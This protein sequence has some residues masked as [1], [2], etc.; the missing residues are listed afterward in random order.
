MRSSSNPFLLSY[1]L[2]FA[3][4]AVVTDTVVTGTV[5]SAQTVLTVDRALAIARENNP[6]FGIADRGL[7]GAQSSRRELIQQR[8]PRVSFHG[9]AVYAPTFPSFGYDPALTNGGQIGAQVMIEHLL[10]DGGRRDLRLDQS[11]IDIDLIGR[12]RLLM[13]RDLR[14]NVEL[15]F[16]DA[17]HARDEV[18]L[19]EVNVQQLADYLR[20]VETM[21]AGSLVGLTDVLKT[22]VRLSDARLAL[23]DAHNAADTARFALAEL[24]GLPFDTLVSVAGRLDSLADVGMF[25]PAANP[26]LAAVDLAVRRSQIEV[27][28][29][30]RENSPTV[31]LLADAGALTS[32]QNI[33]LPRS[34]RSSVVGVS[35]G[36]TV[37]IPIL[38]WGITDLRV[39]QRQI[40]VDTL[41]LQADLLRRS[42][43]RQ[44]VELHA[45]IARGRDRL[46]LIRATIADAEQ[47]FLL[48]KSK[49]AG[50]GGS[51]LEVL[52]AQ[53]LLADNRL[54]E[55]QTL[56]ELQVLI[57][58]L[59]R[60]TTP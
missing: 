12:E 26:D 51:A 53:Q 59:E 35:A 33:T 16:N 39:E 18:A 54:A 45:R 23:D 2:L 19:R 32:V 20:L 5:A 57:A 55:L 38:N 6:R 50:G 52:D 58:R 44:N 14:L 34:E 30:R 25:D 28:L 11:G 46:V 47:N 60:L 29:A 3:A 7:T 43:M 17:M 1:V 4:I 24:I 49:Y 31:S 56:A 10:Y 48:T 9:N 40:A 8:L 42:L 13:E 21:Y 41:R 22:R 27:E 15:A 36:V 37:D